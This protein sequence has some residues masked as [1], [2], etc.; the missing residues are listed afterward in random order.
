M[1]DEFEINV[2]EI[3]DLESAKA[4]IKILLRRIK[5]LEE[6]VAQLKRNSS[7]SS[8]PPSSDIVKP[9]S[10]RRQPG[11]RKSGGQL[12]HKGAKREL[13]PPDKVDETKRIA[14]HCCP[15]CG[16]SVEHCPEK[17][18]RQQVY[19]LTKKPVIV[20]E[21]QREG[22]FCSHCKEIKYAPSPI[23]SEQQYG[24]KL[25][26]FLAYLK[27][28]MGASY[29]ELEDLCQN[30]LNVKITRGSICNLTMGISEKISGFHKKL[31]SAVK[32]ARQ[33]NIDETSWKES[34][35]MNW[36]WLFCNQE[37][38][39]FSIENTRGAKSLK[40]RLGKDFDG[41]VTSDFYGAYNYLPKAKHQFCLAHLIRDI[42]F[43][44]TLPDRITKKHGEKLLSFF[45]RIFDYLHQKKPPDA[46]RKL[47]N[48]LLNF[49]TTLKPPKGCLRTLLKRINRHWHSLWRFIDEPALFHPTNNF[50]ERNLRNLVRLRKVSQGSRSKAGNL[51]IT[52]FSSLYQ[53]AKIRRI[54]PWNMLL[55]EVAR[56]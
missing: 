39:Y 24:T 40:K 19:E 48:R 34:G 35:K 11:V 46:L 29:S 4:I 18:L 23:G 8:K 44:T 42:K 52:R 38:A 53:T 49:L 2:D 28:S 5:I 26:A 47:K 6:E 15:D 9:P 3:K 37:F 36:A 1:A 14:C 22:G 25:Q 43:I 12:G 33:L 13:L 30:V 32:K 54:S 10:E 51:W 41:A 17:I 56:G 21:Y 20:I 31:A 50:A 16:G 27:G 45:K 7:T 55:I